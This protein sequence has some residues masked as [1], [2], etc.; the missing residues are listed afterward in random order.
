MRVYKGETDLVLRWP[1]TFCSFEPD[2]ATVFVFTD[3][4]DRCD[5][6]A[7]ADEFLDGLV[8]VALRQGGRARGRAAAA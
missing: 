6:E 7:A 1:G 3:E 4:G 2:H 8:L 5:D